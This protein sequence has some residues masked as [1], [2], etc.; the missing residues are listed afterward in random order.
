[1]YVGYRFNYDIVAMYIEHL[2]K[3]PLRKIFK[4]SIKMNISYYVLS[5]VQLVEYLL[6]VL[7]S[8]ETVDDVYY[9]PSISYSYV[10][11][12]NNHNIIIN[13]ITTTAIIVL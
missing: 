10:I 3:S 7:V 4:C 6:L 12:Y 2:L 13:I 5:S 9:L 1:M 11:C 8:A